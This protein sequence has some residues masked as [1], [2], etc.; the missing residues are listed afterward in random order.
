MVSLLSV[1]LKKVL[2]IDNSEN[3]EDDDEVVSD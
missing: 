2:K 1:Q 3:K